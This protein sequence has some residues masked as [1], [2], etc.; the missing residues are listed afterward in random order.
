MKDELVLLH[1]FSSRGQSSLDTGLVVHTWESLGV[2]ELLWNLPLLRLPP[3]RLI[4]RRF[5]LQVLS[6]LHIFLPKW[7]PRTV[8]TAALR[9]LWSAIVPPTLQYR[10]QAALPRNTNAAS[11]EW[12][13]INHGSWILSSRNPI[14]SWIIS[15]ITDDAKIQLI[16]IVDLECKVPSQN[17]ASLAM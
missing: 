12:I 6:T 3:L 17:L 7:P 10:P 11:P 8:E 1:L 13:Q 14:I 16:I 2:K 9:R 15:W 5:F 4:S